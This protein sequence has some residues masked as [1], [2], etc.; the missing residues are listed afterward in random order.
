MPTAVGS[1][2]YRLWMYG[3]VMC[4]M[5]N[6]LQGVAVS[7]S[8]FTMTLMSIDRY[9]VICHPLTY[10]QCFCRRHSRWGIIFLWL[11]AASLFIPVLIIRQTGGFGLSMPVTNTD[12]VFVFC[13]EVWKDVWSR[14]FYGLAMFVLVN[15]L[16]A[17]VMTLTYSKIGIQLCYQKQ[18]LT[19]DQPVGTIPRRQTS[20]YRL[21]ELVQSRR[22]VARRFVILT[23][24]FAVCWVP[25][26]IATLL[27][28]FPLQQEIHEGLMAFL[29]FGLFLGHANSAINPLLYCW[30]N[31]RFG[32]DF[33]DLLR[34]R[35]RSTL[36]RERARVI[37][38]AA[39]KEEVPLESRTLNLTST[40]TLNTVK[41]N[42]T[43]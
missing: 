4:K 37:H 8:I 23:L 17:I 15:V 40:S 39:K 6:Y 35:K 25:Y 18:E 16:P 1:I 11:L 21:E 36:Q 38:D 42:S 32:H 34:C 14:R 41:R 24:V 3:D 43:V 12:V 5:T 28:E 26:N 20:S 31:H 33:L 7:A 2:A 27:M 30:L 10:R 9:V 13:V 29:P 19:T 22:V